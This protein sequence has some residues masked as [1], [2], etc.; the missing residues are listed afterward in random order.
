MNNVKKFDF[1][2]LSQVNPKQYLETEE[3]NAIKKGVLL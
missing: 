2:E 1:Q 3:T